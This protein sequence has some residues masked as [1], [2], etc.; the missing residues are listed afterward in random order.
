MDAGTTTRAATVLNTT[1]PS[2]SRRLSELQSASGLKLFD[3]HHGRLRPT[4]EG[5]HLYHSILQHYSGLQKIETLVAV[6]RES[7]TQSL[8]IGCTPSVAAGLLPPVINAF[9]KQYPNTHISIQTLSTRQ[10]EDYL[11]QG[12]IEMAMASG[13]FMQ[14]DFATEVL[15]RTPAICVLP[16]HHPL[17]QHDR[18][19]LDMLANE[20]ILSFSETDELSVRIKQQLVKHGLP[21][22]FSIQTPSSITVCALV[23]AGNGVGIVTPYIAAP[24]ADRLAIT[25]LDPIIEVDLQLAMPSHTAP[26]MLVECFLDLMRRSVKANHLQAGVRSARTQRPPRSDP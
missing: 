8:R 17:A 5:R 21:Q 26:S 3:L 16:L 15:S 23:A 25:Q 7:G 13:E 18:I 1:Q 9:L 22:E 2:I 12:L 24:F 19:S 20:K 6:M 4:A 10:L 11:N 14:G